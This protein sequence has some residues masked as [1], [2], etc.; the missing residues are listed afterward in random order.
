MLLCTCGLQRKTYR[1]RFSPVKVLRNQI[2]GIRLG[3]RAFTCH[4]SCVLDGTPFA[5][6]FLLCLLSRN[7]S[8][9]AYFVESGIEPRD[10]ASRQAL[11]H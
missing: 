9:F 4:P 8:L 2:W 7:R 11:Y 1:S 3:G 5:Q 10:W 6:L